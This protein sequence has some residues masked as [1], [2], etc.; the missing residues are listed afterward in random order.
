MWLL[1]NFKLHL[2]LASH[3]YR[4]VQLQTLNH[5]THCL[6]K[7]T[8]SDWA[9][10][11]GQAL[12]SGF[13]MDWCMTAQPGYWNDQGWETGN[14]LSSLRRA[15]PPP[16]PLSSSYSCTKGFR[17]RSDSGTPHWHSSRTASFKAL[18]AWA[19]PTSTHPSGISGLTASDTTQPAKN[20]PQ[21]PHQAG[22]R[23]RLPEGSSP[24]K[25]EVWSSALLNHA[26]A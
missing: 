25:K 15:Q 4:T 23:G 11:A 21:G 7:T 3:C 17:P 1:E 14:Y 20:S 6:S 24:L 5:S 13:N 18:K 8:S 12:F 16:G 9:A 10:A 26:R 19:R 2:W 22:G